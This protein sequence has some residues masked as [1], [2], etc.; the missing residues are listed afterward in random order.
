MH[1]G[2]IYAGQIGL[3]GSHVLSFPRL[4]SFTTPMIGKVFSQPAA[5]L[6]KPIQ[7][8]VVIWFHIGMSKFVSLRSRVALF[9]R[10][11]FYLLRH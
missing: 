8:G 5:P 6:P 2:T 1:I 7:N 4:T 10:N 11:F 3:A 9:D